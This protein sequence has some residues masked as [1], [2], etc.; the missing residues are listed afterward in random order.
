MDDDDWVVVHAIEHAAVSK[1]VKVPPSWIPDGFPVVSAHTIEM[2]ESDDL[3]TE[4][5]L[6]LPSC[7]RR[8]F[9]TFDKASAEDDPDY[10]AMLDVLRR[11][12]GDDV[13]AVTDMLD[14]LPSICM[15]RH[16]QARHTIVVRYI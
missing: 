5:W 3:L 11:K 8:I 12:Y 16:T 1:L 14:E 6:A 15:A 7:V 2:S 10:N 4:E 9:G 13:P